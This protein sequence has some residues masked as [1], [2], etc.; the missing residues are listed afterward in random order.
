MIALTDLV[1]RGPLAVD[2]V[3]RTL[4]SNGNSLLVGLEPDAAEATVVELAETSQ[5]LWHAANGTIASVSGLL[6]GR[7]FCTRVEAN[8]GVWV[9]VE[10]DLAMLTFSN[11]LELR[12]ESGQELQKLLSPAPESQARLYGPTGWLGTDPRPSSICFRISPEGLRVRAQDDLTDGAREAAALRE[13]AERRIPAGSSDWTAPLVLDALALDPKAFTQPTL[14]VSVLLTAIGLEQRGDDWG[15]A[16]EDWMSTADMFI[17]RQLEELAAD[18]ALGEDSQ[19]L[20]VAVGE[21]LRWLRTEDPETDFRAAAAALATGCV[22]QPFFEF[23]MPAVQTPSERDATF[24]QNLTEAGWEGRV[25]GSYI[26]GRVAAWTGDA[27]SAEA[28]FTLSAEADPSFA[29]PRREL[30]VFAM[31]RGDLRPAVQMLTAAG[32]EDEPLVGALNWLRSSAVTVGHGTGRNEPCPCGS[33][34]K[35]KACCLRAPKLTPGSLRDQLDVRLREFLAG[36]PLQWQVRKMAELLVD[37]DPSTTL[38]EAYADPVLSDAVLAEGGGFAQYLKQRA[39]AIEAQELETLQRW[40]RATRAVF[41]V[42]EIKGEEL[43][44]RNLHSGVELQSDLFAMVA[45]EPGD[46]LMTRV[47]L[48]EAGTSG[49]MLADPLLLPGALVPDAKRLLDAHPTPEQLVEWI[50]LHPSIRSLD[51]TDDRRD[52]VQTGAMDPDLGDFDGIDLEAITAAAV[53]DLRGGT[54]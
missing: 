10:P 4:V 42:L 22:A 13:A 49:V 32:F 53:R 5:G 26:A 41:E 16:G 19:H 43:R 9:P 51:L 38:L 3:A 23:L 31:D 47:G 21:Y 15:R 27:S 34:Q 44:L 25:A 6:Q 12:L 28:L 11:S 35:F 33:G 36:G 52:A 17:K 50:A 8:S 39:F 2:H 14:P 48:M 30:A 46:H 7:V 54:N 18:F 45:P 1:E 29:P 24:V 37:V 40:S 20:F